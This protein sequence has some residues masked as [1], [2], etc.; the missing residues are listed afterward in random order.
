M[1]VKENMHHSSDLQ[2]SL[3]DANRSQI[4]AGIDMEFRS[5]D[6]FYFM[7]FVHESKGK[8]DRNGGG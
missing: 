7:M 8:K 5:I 6:R 2:Q 3:C 4:E 1:L